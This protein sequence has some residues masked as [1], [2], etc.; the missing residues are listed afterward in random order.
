MVASVGI[1]GAGNI[2]E[3][4]QFQL[5]FGSNL[6]TPDGKHC[7]A[8][9]HQYGCTIPARQR[10]PGEGKPPWRFEI[11]GEANPIFTW[12][13]KGTTIPTRPFLG[14]SQR[15]AEQISDVIVQFVADQLFVS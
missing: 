2:N 7:L 11:H 12:K 1:G 14:I 3:I 9:I 10:K 8:A 4:S 6:M 13:I 15:L 5:V